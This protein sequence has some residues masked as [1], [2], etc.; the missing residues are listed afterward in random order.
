VQRGSRADGAHH[1]HAR[2]LAVGAFDVDD[3][4]TLPHAQVDGL[5]DQLVQFTHRGQCSITH[6]QTALDQVAQLQQTHAQAIAAGFGPVHETAH[7]QVVEDAVCGRR[8]Q[9][10]FLADFL[11]GNG[12]LAAGQHIDQGEHAFDHLDGRRG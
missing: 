9:S 4:V 6:I 10:C 5:L 8:M 2:T 12:I 1:L 11:E 3:F 7:R